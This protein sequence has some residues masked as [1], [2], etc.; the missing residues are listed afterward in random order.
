M[1]E[2]DYNTSPYAYVMNNPIN[3]YDILGLTSEMVNPGFRDGVWSMIEG[4]WS[5]ASGGSTTYSGDELRDTY[6]EEETGGSTTYSINYPS[7]RRYGKMSHQVRGWGFQ[8]KTFSFTSYDSPPDNDP[9]RVHTVKKD[10]TIWSISEE[11]A[12]SM[13]DILK[14]PSSHEH[15]ENIEKKIKV[16]NFNLFCI[17]E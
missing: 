12:V 17:Q 8:M 11:Y 6:L 4:A 3:M 5:G 1:A 9:W 14:Y 13:E 7:L 16:L 10:E 15:V 2:W